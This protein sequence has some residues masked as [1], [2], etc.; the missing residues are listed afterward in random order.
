MLDLFVTGYGARTPRNMICAADRLRSDQDG[1]G[2]EPHK[3]S[4]CH[5]IAASCAPLTRAALLPATHLPAKPTRASLTPAKLIALRLSAIAL[6]VGLLGPLFWSAAPAQAAGSCGR[7]EWRDG[8]PVFASD[9]T[10]SANLRA[11]AKKRRS[12]RVAKPPNDLR[13]NSVPFKSYLMLDNLDA[14]IGRYRAVVNKGGWPKIAKGRYLRPDQ[15]DYRVP[16]LRKRLI[17]A[18]DLNLRAGVRSQS[19]DRAVMNAVKRFQIRHG[20]RANGIVGT[21]TLAHLNISAAQR[22]RQLQVNRHRLA[23]L[24]AQP[25]DGRYVLVNIPAFQL[26]A[27]EG[28]EVVQ[29]HRVIVGKQD[30]QTPVLK[31]TIRGLNFFP[32]WRVPDSIAHRDIIPRLRK[33]PGYLDKQFI[34]VLDSFGGNII[35]PATVDWFSPEAK[36]LKFR[37][38]PGKHNALGLVRIDMPNKHIVYLHDTPMKQLFNSNSR[39]FSAGCVRVQNVFKFV[40]WIAS[41]EEGWNRDRIDDVLQTGVAENLRLKKRIPVYFTYLT[42][43]ADPQ[44]P[45]QFRYDL[46]GRDGKEILSDLRASG[47]VGPPPPQGLSP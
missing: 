24:L 33:E 42:A 2:G 43:W 13:K 11:S 46:Y 6:T 27:V 12:K 36:K 4:S 39:S 22:L 34:R 30:R 40:N 29:R 9:C 32:F 16:N 41:T 10:R 15:T 37:Q 18:G 28:N 1:D 17:I 31:A 5:S 25:R 44:G 3:P 20:L 45:V 38:D 19:Y 26:E 14:A 7:G 47:V 23:K 21:R 35:D 8:V